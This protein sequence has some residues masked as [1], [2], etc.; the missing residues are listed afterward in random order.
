MEFTSG[1]EKIFQMFDDLID[2][3]IDLIK[4]IGDNVTLRRRVSRNFNSIG[5]LSKTKSALHIYGFTELGLH[6]QEPSN[7]DLVNCFHIG[8]HYKVEYDIEFAQHLAN[9]SGISLQEVYAITHGEVKEQWELDALDEF[10]RDHDDDFLSLYSNIIKYR[11]I[12]TYIRKRFNVQSDFRKAFGID[13]RLHPAH[14]RIGVQAD[15]QDGHRFERLVERCFVAS[16]E[17]VMTDYRH[18]NCR[19]DFVTSNNHWIDAKLSK[20][21]SFS[22]SE[23]IE[24][25]TKHADYLTLIYAIDDIEDEEVPHI[26]DNVNLIHILDYFNELPDDLLEDVQRFIDGVLTRRKG[27]WS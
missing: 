27:R 2:A 22:G 5:T 7:A 18:A 3:E 25:Y 15:I 26:E 24:K 1:Q 16:G 13:F 21:T 17:D 10:V 4:H 19:P 6:T 12:N 9:T 23:T 8:E 14:T 11:H 20:S